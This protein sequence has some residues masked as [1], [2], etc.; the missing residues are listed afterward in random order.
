[1]MKD[2]TCC[3]D[4]RFIVGRRQVYG[5]IYSMGI[6]EFPDLLATS[7]RLMSMERFRDEYADCAAH[8]EGKHTHY[9][10]PE[11]RERPAP[12]CYKPHLDTDRP[13]NEYLPHVHVLVTDSRSRKVNIRWERGS[14]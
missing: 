12:I 6:G 10:H 13:N 9:S 8:V 4:W 7:Q 3:C 11:H 5:P 1:M 14:D 2:F